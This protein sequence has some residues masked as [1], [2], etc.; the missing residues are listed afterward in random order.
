MSLTYGRV[1]RHWGVWVLVSL[2]VH[3]LWLLGSRE[4]GLSALPAPAPTVLSLGLAQQPRP[5]PEPETRLEPAPVEPARV[6]TPPSPPKPATKPPDPV[7]TSP[8]ARAEPAAPPQASAVA[9][10]PSAPAPAAANPPARVEPAQSEPVIT[11]SP[12]YAEPPAR[13]A[14]PALA[15]RRGWQGEVWLEIEVGPEG[16]SAEPVLL[17]SSG[18]E[19][20]DK[21]ALEVARQWRFVPEQRNGR[22]VATRVRIPV[23]FA[24]R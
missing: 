18:F 15:R 21:A 5:A 20:L 22:P 9:S 11:Q 8:V 2:L 17:R 12:R 6:A 10:A 3:G 4:S 14:Y 13:P 23:Q 19:L 24:L 7:A 16:R 1:L